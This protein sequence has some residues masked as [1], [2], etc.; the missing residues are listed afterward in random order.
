[1][2]AEYNA[3]PVSLGH[4]DEVIAFDLGGTSFRSALLTRN[5]ELSYAQ[6]IPSMNCRSLPGRSPDDIVH[7][8]GTY[9]MHTVEGLRRASGSSAR[10]T[11]IA[12]CMG[13]ALSAH[14]VKILGSVLILG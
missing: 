7:G 13:A 4:G 1:M 9:V 6:R 14:T 8:I 5:G 2:M 10:R 12:I 3:F 11:S